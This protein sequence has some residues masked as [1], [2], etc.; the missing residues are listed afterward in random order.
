MDSIPTA[1]RTDE[2]IAMSHWLPAIEATD[3]PT[4]ETIRI[5]VEHDDDGRP[6]WDADEIKNAVSEL[7]G[8]AFVRTGFKSAQTP[9]A[10]HIR[11]ATDEQVELTMKELVFDMVMM[12]LPLG[13]NYYIR[14]WLDLTWDHYVDGD[15]HPEARFFIRDGE[16][17]CCHLRTDFPD[18][19]AHDPAK[20]KRYFDPSTNDFNGLTEEVHEYAET[21]ANALDGEGWYSVDFVL[22]TDYEWYLTD[23]AIDALYYHEE[24]GWG[25]V[26][27]H[28]GDCEHSLD[29]QLATGD[30]NTDELSIE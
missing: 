9:R 10:Q 5:P 8:E 4:P 15:C 22:T 18:T 7:G 23:A 3:I 13:N 17:T 28:P 1:S 26:S 11:S 12:Q 14:E 30:I 19:A 6:T 29:T 20:A 21:A 25:G 27:D 2:R 24:R 16:V